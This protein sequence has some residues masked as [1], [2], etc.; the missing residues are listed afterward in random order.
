MMDGGQLES[1]NSNFL[2]SSVIFLSVQNSDIISLYACFPQNKQGRRSY[3]NCDKESM[4][5]IQVSF[6]SVY[7]VRST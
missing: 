6:Y 4:N 1:W 7:A 2:M 5:S 3:S